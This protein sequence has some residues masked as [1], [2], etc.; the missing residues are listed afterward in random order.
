MDFTHFYYDFIYVFR[1]FYMHLE[2]FLQTLHVQ[3]LIGNI[4]AFGS[5][6]SFEESSTENLKSESIIKR[7]ID[8]RSTR[9]VDR[10]YNNPRV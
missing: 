4:G 1:V 2:S 5:F 6:W 3:V 8:L 10:H 7:S 9:S